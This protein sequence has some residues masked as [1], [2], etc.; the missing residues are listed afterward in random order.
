MILDDIYRY[1]GNYDFK[2]IELEFLS[3]K[4]TSD[5]AEKKE[6]RPF[7]SDPYYNKVLMS[8]FVWV[9]Y[10]L[11]DLKGIPISEIHSFFVFKNW[12]YY[13]YENFRRA[14]RIFKKNK[15]FIKTKEIV[16]SHNLSTS[17]SQHISHDK[18]TDI[19][20]DFPKID[21]NPIS[22]KKAEKPVFS[23]QD[24]LNKDGIDIHASAEE[25]RERISVMQKNLKQRRLERSSNNQSNNQSG[26]NLKE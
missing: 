21:Q 3:Y 4:M 6:S 13:K 16:D 24:I 2:A 26:N 11:N 23:A 10:Y 5:L 17:F 18:P 19:K 14:Y 9:I 7:V 20:N 15:I 25:N 22:D 8:Q 12:T 1:S